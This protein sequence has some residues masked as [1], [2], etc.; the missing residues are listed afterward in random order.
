M[1]KNANT[2]TNNNNNIKMTHSCFEN[3]TEKA[4]RK[5]ALLWSVEN[6][7]IQSF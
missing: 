2:T 1:Y 6:I 5:N 3:F 4:K 7:L